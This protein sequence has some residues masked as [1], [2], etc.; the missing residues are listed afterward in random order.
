MVGK[1]KDN[2]K[3]LEEIGRRMKKISKNQNGGKKLKIRFR[4]IIY[5][6]NILITDY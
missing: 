5:P 6:L 2:G 1:M 4:K 3:K